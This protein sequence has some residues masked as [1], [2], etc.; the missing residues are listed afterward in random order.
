MAEGSAP[1][2]A[3]TNIVSAVKLLQ[4]QLLK[5]QKV[6]VAILQQL[7][8]LQQACLLLLFHPLSVR[9]LNAC[10]FLGVAKQVGFTIA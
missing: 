7:S 3:E 2:V 4:E 9:G 10:L 1:S 6:Q 5:Q 8:V